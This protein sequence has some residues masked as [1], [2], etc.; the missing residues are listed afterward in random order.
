MSKYRERLYSLERQYVEGILKEGML[1][2]TIHRDISNVLME[3]CDDFAEKAVEIVYYF[4]DLI[5]DVNFSSDFLREPVNDIDLNN[6]SNKIYTKEII[7]AKNYVERLLDVDLS[8]VSII[9][10]NRQIKAHAEGFCL[11]CGKDEHYIFYQDDEYGVISTDL[12]IHE[13]GHA[14]EFTISRNESSD[15]IFNRHSCI[16]EAIAYYCQ[17]RYLLDF[18]SREQRMGSFGAF[19]D[20]YLKIIICRVC[21]KHDTPLSDIDV[22]L[23]VN[24]DEC[25]SIIDSYNQ[26]SLYTK[27]F[28]ADRV[29]TIKNIHPNLMSLVYHDIEPKFG[30]ALAIL[31]LNKPQSFIRQIIENNTFDKKLKSFVEGII[32]ECHSSITDLETHFKQYFGSR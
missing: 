13:L 27:K 23:V 17:F 25:Y 1:S 16:S 5:H 14:A 20:A 19:L 29:G 3:T 31:L 9:K 2:E 18:G 10:L 8:G 11:P 15:N 4:F 21:I 7:Q 24:S 30:A 22:Q 32:S 12:I 6:L 28:I 26:N